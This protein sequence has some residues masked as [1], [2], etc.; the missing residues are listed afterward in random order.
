MTTRRDFIVKGCTACMGLVG[1]GMLLEGCS[2]ALPVFNAVANN[3]SFVVPLAKFTEQNTN[4]LLLRNPQLENDILLVKENN[5]YK[6]LLMKCTHEGYGLVVA[7]NKIHCNV[8]GSEFDMNGNV[9]KSP[10]TRALQQ[11]KTEVINSNIII[12]LT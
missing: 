5:S 1:L 6:A 4:L 12:H 8:H 7:K 9:L 3:K 2:T 10:A 11:F